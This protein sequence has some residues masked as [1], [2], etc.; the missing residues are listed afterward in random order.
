MATESVELDVSEEELFPPINMIKIAKNKKRIANPK[1][2][3]EMTFSDPLSFVLAKTFKPPPVIAPE[4]PSDL[5]P[6]RR[7]RTM[8][9]KEIMMKTISYHCIF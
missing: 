1:V 3:Q 4:A 2:N 8:T 5:P 7:L 6:W 9:I